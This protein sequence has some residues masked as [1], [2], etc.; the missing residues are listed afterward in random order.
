MI[1]IISALVFF[2]VANPETFKMVR[3]LVGSWVATPTG[4]PSMLGLFLHAVVFMLVVWGMMNIKREKMEGEE[5]M[6]EE[7]M[8]EEPPTSPM[9]EPE[10]MPEPMT[11]PVVQQ[12]PT[13]MSKVLGMDMGMADAM[14][15]GT[16]KTCGCSDGSRVVIMN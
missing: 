10:P 3:R 14:E 4:C 2:I 16:Y 12:P 1:S 5:V 11:E 7:M 9:P 13:M 8:I 6:E 15:S